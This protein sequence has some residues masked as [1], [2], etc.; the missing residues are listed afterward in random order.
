MTDDRYA[1][2]L[3]G[4]ST[5]HLVRVRLVALLLL[6]LLLLSLLSCYGPIQRFESQSPVLHRGLASSVA[7]SKCGQVGSTINLKASAR[8]GL[9]LGLATSLASIK[10]LGGMFVSST[11][12]TVLVFTVGSSPILMMLWLWSQDRLRT[13]EWMRWLLEEMSGSYGTRGY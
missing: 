13:I 3:I 4:I 5:F 8:S 7:K 10:A 2:E 1:V 6:L 12:T 9:V 11:R